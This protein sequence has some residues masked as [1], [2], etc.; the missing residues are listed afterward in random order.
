MTSVEPFMTIHTI[1]ERTLAG[2]NFSAFSMSSVLFND[3]I[4]L[5]HKCA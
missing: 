2:Q 4:T 3:K 5:L 1:I